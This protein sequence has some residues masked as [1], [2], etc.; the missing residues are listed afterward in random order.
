MYNSLNNDIVLI[1]DINGQLYLFDTLTKAT[2]SI[3]II[4]LFNQQ[5][6]NNY[7]APALLSTTSMILAIPLTA[8]LHLIPI[9]S[10]I[11]TVSPLLSLL[12]DRSTDFLFCHIPLPLAFVQNSCLHQVSV[13]STLVLYTLQP[14]IRFTRFYHLQLLSPK[15]NAE[16]VPSDSL[17][18]RAIERG[19]CFIAF[20][21]YDGRVILQVCYWLPSLDP[22]LQMPRGNYECIYPRYISIQ[23][24]I[25]L[26]EQHRFNEMIEKMRR[27][28]LRI[29]IVIFC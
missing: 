7:C 1:E 8:L 22:L 28:K 15:L 26:Y 18:S 9:T 4:I 5:I 3:L 14:G 25:K 12:F 21:N 13:P 11:S 2:T 10:S 16:G 27:E 23:I 24:F 20:G 6:T 19:S 17:L 29:S